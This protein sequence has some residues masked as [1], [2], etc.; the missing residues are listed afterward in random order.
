MV[1]GLVVAKTN[2]FSKNEKIRN[3]KKQFINVGESEYKGIIQQ[4]I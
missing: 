2:I 4:I 3:N 1:T